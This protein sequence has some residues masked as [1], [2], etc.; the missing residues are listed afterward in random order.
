MGKTSVRILFGERKT[1][2]CLEMRRLKKMMLM[3]LNILKI[4]AVIASLVM[5]YRSFKQLYSCTFL[6][7]SDITMC[8]IFLLL[9]QKKGKT[10]VQRMFNVF[11]GEL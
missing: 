8:L 2:L 3:P 5:C 9:L 10:L 4:V 6:Y 7:I 1:K 11:L